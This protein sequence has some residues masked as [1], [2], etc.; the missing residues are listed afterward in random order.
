MLYYLSNIGQDNPN[1]TFTYEDELEKLNNSN[2][3][4]CYDSTLP[5][6]ACE[7]TNSLFLPKIEGNIKTLSIMK[8]NEIMDKWATIYQLFKNSYESK[9]ELFKDISFAKIDKD[10]IYSLDQILKLSPTVISAGASND[11][12]IFI[13]AVVNGKKIHFDIF[14]ENENSEVLLNI[15]ENKK[16][17]CIYEGILEEAICKLKEILGEDIYSGSEYELSSTFTATI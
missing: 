17:L 6:P 14:F 2:A 8:N 11:E 5:H 4:V 15:T 12:C 7:I 10:F 13:Y 16:P 3:I 9:I 1:L